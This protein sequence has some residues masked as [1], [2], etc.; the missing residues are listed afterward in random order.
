MCEQLAGISPHKVGCVS[1]ATG[2]CALIGQARTP[3][4]LTPSLPL[5]FLAS[6]GWADWHEASGV[7]ALI[8][9]AARVVAGSTLLSTGHSRFWR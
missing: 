3:Y 9:N 2:C 6:S 1:D 5:V 8:K 7:V 4:S